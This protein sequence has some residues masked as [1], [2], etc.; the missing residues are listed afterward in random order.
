MDR[1]TSALGH[2]DFEDLIGQLELIG[3]TLKRF[4]DEEV[5]DLLGILN[6]QTEVTAFCGAG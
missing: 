3:L 4:P 5:I 6:A 1:V 2:E